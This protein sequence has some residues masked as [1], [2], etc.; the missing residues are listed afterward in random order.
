MTY[1]LAEF[2]EDIYLFHSNCD[3]PNVDKRTPDT[4]MWEALSRQVNIIQSELTELETAVAVRDK[5]EML[6]GIVDVL[7]TSLRLVGLMEERYDVTEA[8]QRI[9]ENNAL[10]YREYPFKAS[11][12]PEGCHQVVV[13]GRYGNTYCLKDATGKVRKYNNFPKVDLSDLA[14]EK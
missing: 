12:I 2:E 9:A 3:I 10:K 1:S 14:E 4:E 7:Y 11:E 6:D 5:V 13:E 8:C